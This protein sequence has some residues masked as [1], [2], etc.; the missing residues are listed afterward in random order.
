MRGPIGAWRRDSGRFRASSD[1]GANGTCGA[2]QGAPFGIALTT[3]GGAIVLRSSSLCHAGAATTSRLPST[4]GPSA[5][6]PRGACGAFGTT[7]S[8]ARRAGRTASRATATG[9]S[10]CASTLVAS[11]CLPTGSYTWP[12]SGRSPT[13]GSSGTA[14]ATGPRITHRTFCSCPRRSVSGPALLPL[15]PPP[16]LV[17]LVGVAALTSRSPRTNRSEPR[18]VRQAQKR[19]PDGRG[20]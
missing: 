8:P 11:A 13:A 10:T 5:W 3:Q 19:G 1:G 15:A 17:Y 6:I 9:P 16:P 12:S 18:H 4:W 2:G 20:T 14:T 7:V